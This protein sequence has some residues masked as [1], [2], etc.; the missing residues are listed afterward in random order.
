M[1]QV[2]EQIIEQEPDNKQ[3]EEPNLF[4]NENINIYNLNEFSKK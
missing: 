2:I 4:I 3:N 1:E